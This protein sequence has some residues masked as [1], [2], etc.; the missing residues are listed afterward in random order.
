SEK[1]W[2]LSSAICSSHS[3]SP[4]SEGGKVRPSREVTSMSSSQVIITSASSMRGG[5]SLNWVPWITGPYM[6]RHRILD[7]GC[8]LRLGR[9]SEQQR[10]P[11][12][13]F[14]QDPQRLPV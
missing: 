11:A 6:T 3:R 13:A 2:F 12:V 10:R 14:L 4:S 1:I 8:G 9:P 7:G 5:R